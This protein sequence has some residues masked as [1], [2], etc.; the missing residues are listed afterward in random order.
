MKIENAIIGL[1]VVRSKGDHVVGFIGDI[2]EI[3]TE[4]NRVRVN[5]TNRGAWKALKT[6]VKIEVIEPTS[7]PYEIIKGYTKNNHLRTWVWQKYKTL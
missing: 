1:E 7:I 4:K 6:W 3:D 2:L 5:W